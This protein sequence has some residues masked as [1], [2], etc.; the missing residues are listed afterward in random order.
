MTTKE[1]AEKYG[2]S[3][4]RVQVLIKEGRIPARKVY[5][6]QYSIPDD[7]I[8][9]RDERQSFFNRHFIECRRQPISE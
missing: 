1:F 6:H 9:P 3:V 2:V 5:G 8:Y 7:A 4:R